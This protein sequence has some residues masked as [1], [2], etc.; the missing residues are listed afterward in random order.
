MRYPRHYSPMNSKLKHLCC[1]TLG[2]F[3]DFTLDIYLPFP[4]VAELKEYDIFH[5][6][7]WA[8]LG[9]Q[10][11]GEKITESTLEK[12][13]ILM[14]RELK[15][16]FAGKRNKYL[17]ITGSDNSSL[18]VIKLSYIYSSASQNSP[19]LSPHLDLEDD[20]RRY[21][22][23]F[24]PDTEPDY[25]EDY[26]HGIDFGQDLELCFIEPK[27]LFG[28]EFFH[29]RFTLGLG[30]KLLI[31]RFGSNAMDI[32]MFYYWTDYMLRDV[33]GF[34]ERAGKDYFNLFDLRTYGDLDN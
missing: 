29:L 1:G 15:E 32:Q 34:N 24:Y 22:K 7:T 23:E 4:T 17:D 10:L 20:L 16:D 11:D 3:K 8:N 19:H 25:L 14:L 31:D 27:N 9:S 6:N 2:S 13:K 33:D 5:F 18:I 28:Y 21:V 12:Y 30:A 26:L